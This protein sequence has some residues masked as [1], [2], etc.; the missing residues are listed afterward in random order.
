[1]ARSFLVAVVIGLLIVLGGTLWF[2]AGMH[3]VSADAGLIELVHAYYQIRLYSAP[4]T[5]SLYVVFGAMIGLQRMR[6]LLLLQLLLNLSNIT[7]NILIYQ[8]T[9]WHVRGVATATVISECVT[10][11]V[12]LWQLRT[13]IVPIY[14]RWPELKHRFT[15][16]D[17]FS[18]LWQISR[19]LFIR[20]I[21]LTIAFYWMTAL[22]SHQGAFVL[23]ANSILIHLLHLMAHW[24]DGF[25]HAA[26]SLVGFAYGRKDRQAFRRA[27]RMSTEL[28]LVLAVFM[29]A[30]YAIFGDTLVQLISR[31]ATVQTE[32]AKYLGWI[33]VSPLIG[34]WSFMLDGIFTGITHTRPMRN[35]MLISLVCFVI[36]A[37][38]LIPL[39]GNHGLWLAYTILMLTRAVT[40]G[41]SLRRISFLTHSV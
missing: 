29:T 30:L 32:A 5:L 41:L 28:A 2:R 39:M 7:L 14:H 40:L 19:D 8:L 27:I 3:F 21:C 31:D 10:L 15:N 38:L 17:A 11:I 37:Y 23:A 26:E 33:I 6:N 4:V 20:T 1:M 24:L 16:R 36:S 22:G 12:A 13:H 9:D 35:G 18:R 34:V 25:A